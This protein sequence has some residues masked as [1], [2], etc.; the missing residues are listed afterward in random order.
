MSDEWS[1]KQ[2]DDKYVEPTNAEIEVPSDVVPPVVEPTEPT[3]PVEPKADD[4]IVSTTE[5]VEPKEIEYDDSKVLEIVKQKLGVEVNSFEDLKPK[6]QK[7][8]TPEIE[9][10]LQF[11]EETG[12]SNYSDFI[13]TQK[14][15]TQEDKSS[16]LKA[17]MKAQNP[18]LDER[19]INFLFKQKYSFDE[20]IDDEDQILE[21]TISE[22]QDYHKALEL[23]EQQKEKYKVPSGSEE[24]I[25]EPYKKAKEYVDKMQ[26][27]QQV[28][29]Q[30]RQVFEQ[31]TERV[32]SKDF[33]GFKMN[34]DG[35]DYS[36]KPENVELT[37]KQQLDLSNFE[38]KYFD[39]TGK[40]VNAEHYHL[41]LFA[42][43]DP[44]KFAKHF[45]EI[46]K[47][48]FAEADEARSKN[49]DMN[50]QSVPHSSS[51]KSDWQVRKVD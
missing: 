31:E 22:K 11:Q 2:V 17:Y 51:G 20:D 43:N 38:K 42:A 48:E 37:K 39:E 27:Q 44:V 7:K 4:V 15:W 19:E 1:V 33:E 5:P 9:K 36:I 18:M 13:Q 21:K 25:P 40:I 26:Q 29:Q 14:D 49:I 6:E 45:I 32:F 8:L 16:V 24:L 12:N 3:E 35:K 34:I 46:G 41:A 10:F 47:A 50:K 23:L 30:S 28:V